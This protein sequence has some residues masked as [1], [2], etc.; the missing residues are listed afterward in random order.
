MTIFP[1]LAIALVVFSVNLREDAPRDVLD[2]RMRGTSQDAG[3]IDHWPSKTLWK[4]YKI[5]SVLKAGI[6]SAVIF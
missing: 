5:P 1:G 6:L 4:I 3:H 2:P